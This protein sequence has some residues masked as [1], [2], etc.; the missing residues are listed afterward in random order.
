MPGEDEPKED[1]KDLCFSRVL[2][3][4]CSASSA[5]RIR[6]ASL[7]AST[8][9]TGFLTDGGKGPPPNPESKLLPLNPIPSKNDLFVSCG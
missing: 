1:E 5:E 2:G 7:K 8:L 4:G 9:L 3:F 6:R